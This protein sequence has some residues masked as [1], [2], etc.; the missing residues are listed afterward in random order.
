MT[1]GIEKEVREAYR[2]DIVL[3][4]LTLWCV[5]QGLLPSTWSHLKNPTQQ[6][7]EM[8]SIF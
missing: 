6:T 3:R 1:D 2:C 7:A 4:L 5:K 8:D